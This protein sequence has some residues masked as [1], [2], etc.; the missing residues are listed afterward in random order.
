ML[1]AFHVDPSASVNSGGFLTNILTNGI[2]QVFAIPQ[3][4]KTAANDVRRAEDSPRPP[5]D[6]QHYDKDALSRHMNAVFKYHLTHLS[7]GVVVHNPADMNPTDPLSCTV[8]V[9]LDHI[10]I[11]TDE[12]MVSG[13]AT[14]DLCHLGIMHQHMK[15]TVVR[16][17]ISRM[18][19]INQ[20]QVIIMLGMPGDM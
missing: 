3:I 6:G 17:V 11:I 12:D 15:L 13:D 20:L 14:L 5:L 9:K 16:N 18:K 2:D 19:S 8:I 7:T 4:D 10:A 1:E